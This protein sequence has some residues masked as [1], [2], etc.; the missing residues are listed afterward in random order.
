MKGQSAAE[1]TAAERPRAIGA[2]AMLGA[3]SR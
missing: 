3:P 2:H 1:P